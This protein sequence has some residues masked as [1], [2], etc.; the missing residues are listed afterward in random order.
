MLSFKDPC[1][2]F[3]SILFCHSY[4]PGPAAL[5]GTVP[6]GHCA[7][8]CVQVILTRDLVAHFLLLQNGG[9]VGREGRATSPGFKG[10]YGSLYENS[11][12]NC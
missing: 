3:L 11:L 4:M 1:D 10:N 2:L 8:E 6:L 7:I 9:G 5:K 12:V